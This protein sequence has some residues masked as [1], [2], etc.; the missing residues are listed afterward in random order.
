MYPIPITTRHTS[1]L[2]TEMKTNHV[3]KIGPKE[4]C[5]FSHGL[6][7]GE[8]LVQL[9]S[10][11]ISIQFAISLKTIIIFN[12]YTYTDLIL[13]SP[14]K[15]VISRLWQVQTRPGLANSSLHTR[16]I[17]ARYARLVLLPSLT[18]A[19]YQSTQTSNVRL[20]FP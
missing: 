6:S 10:C 4:I 17:G 11:V 1:Y 9:S 19:I 13:D 7:T 16:S 3:D 8:T 12:F 18:F 5:L 14:L 2:N 20:N 15:M